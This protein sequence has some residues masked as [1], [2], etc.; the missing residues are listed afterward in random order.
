MSQKKPTCP[1]PPTVFNPA[2]TITVLEQGICLFRVHPKTF[3][4]TEFNPG[5]GLPGR[6]SPLNDLNGNNIPTLYAGSSNKSALAES[7]FRNVVSTSPTITR[8][9]LRNQLLSTIIPT[10][11]LRL[12][13]LSQN[14]LRRLGLK[15]NQLLETGQDSYAQ[16]ACWAKALHDHNDHCDGIVWVSTQFDTEKSFLLFGD[17]VLSDDLMITDQAHSIHDGPGFEWVMEFANDAG[18]TIFL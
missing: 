4:A 15:R 12:V 10:R 1:T 17:R 9:S 7:V 2:P 5:K 8:L 18:I 11:N 6:F 13:D 3:A 14:G 16:T